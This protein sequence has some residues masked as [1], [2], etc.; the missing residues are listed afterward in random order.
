MRSTL[1]GFQLICAKMEAWR[2]RGIEGE[3][4]YLYLGEMVMTRA[5]WARLENHKKLPTKSGVLKCDIAFYLLQQNWISA[6][7]LR[8]S[9]THPGMPSSS[10]VT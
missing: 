5:R 9:F 4:R 7:G 3:L 2:N 6:P 8:A 1:E 10:R